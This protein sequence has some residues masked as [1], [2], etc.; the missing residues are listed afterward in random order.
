MA[1]RFKQNMY[2]TYKK[3]SGSDALV[4]FTSPSFE[5]TFLFRDKLTEKIFEKYNFYL[6][7][8]EGIPVKSDSWFRF[9][10]CENEKL[11]KDFLY[12]AHP[13]FFAWM[14]KTDKWKDYKKEDQRTK[15]LVRLDISTSHD[16]T[17][18][19]IYSSIHSVDSLSRLIENVA[20]ELG[21][22][23]P[24]NSKLPAMSDIIMT[25]KKF[26]LYKT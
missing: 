19:E 22:D 25:N 1:P 18:I 10:E 20:K 23:M 26:S 6:H 5:S 15:N 14:F 21:I 4:C 9:F 12:K 13:G 2:Q 11:A 3:D 24:K 7:K 8:S 16:H 17:C